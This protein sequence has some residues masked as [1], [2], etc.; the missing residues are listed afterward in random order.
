MVHEDATD[1]C[2]VVV[3]GELRLGWYENGRF[4]TG[5][6]SGVL[7]HVESFTHENFMVF[8]VIHCGRT[9]QI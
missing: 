8:L 9:A 7:N 3:E 6:V 1:G 5:G 4:I 2:F